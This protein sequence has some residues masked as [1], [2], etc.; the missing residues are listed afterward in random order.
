[1]TE[2]E[3]I[4]YWIEKFKREYSKTFPND[5]LGDAETQMFN[6]DGKKLM[7]GSEFFGSYELIDA[8]N[9]TVLTVK[10]LEEAKYYIYASRLKPESFPVPIKK[11]IL[12]KAVKEWD[13]LLDDFLKILLKDYKSKFENSPS[14]N[15]ISSKI[16]LS[17]DLQRF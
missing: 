4:N 11:E 15:K 3:F 5:F 12:L 16:F 13:N 6:N 17:L 1:M 14:F 9:N 7:L 8:N 2:K 10:S